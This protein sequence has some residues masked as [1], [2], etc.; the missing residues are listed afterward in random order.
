MPIVLGVALASVTE[1]S[2][3]WL[4]FGAAMLSNLSFASRNIF[5][6]LSMDKPKGENMNPAN[7]MGV[8][9]CMAFALSL[10]FALIKEGM[11]AKAAVAAAT[12]SP[13]ALASAIC[14]CGA[15]FYLYNEI[16]MLALNNVHPVTHAVANTIKRVVIL[17]ACVFIFKTPMS[18]ACWA[19]SAIAIAGSFGYSLAKRHSDSKAAAA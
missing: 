8:L 9:T 5:S 17:L 2:F 11:S 19:G 14:V 4:A 6:R 16:A 7:M 13:A 12:M 10:P 1:L 15:Y 3:T 18:K